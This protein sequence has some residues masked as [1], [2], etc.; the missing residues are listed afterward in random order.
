[1]AM[2]AGVVVGGIERAANGTVEFEEEAAASE[3]GRQT[4]NEI[5]AAEMVP[6]LALVT[7]P[8]PPFSIGKAAH[9][10][11]IVVDSKRSRSRFTFDGRDVKPVLRA[12]SGTDPPDDR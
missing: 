11:G 2:M 12:R 10:P 4:R 5:T 3:G 7:V 1:M 6:K 8:L 9:V